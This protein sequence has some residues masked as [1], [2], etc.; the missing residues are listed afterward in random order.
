MAVGYENINRLDKRLFT[1]ARDVR[2][3][4]LQHGLAELSTPKACTK[5]GDK[6]ACSKCDCVRVIAGARNLLPLPARRRSGVCGVRGRR[7]R[8]ARW[9]VRGGMDASDLISLAR[10]YISAF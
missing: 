6:R 1:L 5:R 10:D 7:V 3:F 2:D 9:Y 4:G 8:G